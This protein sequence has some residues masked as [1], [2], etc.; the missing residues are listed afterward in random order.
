MKHYGDFLIEKLG[1]HHKYQ[2]LLT[3]NLFIIGFCA[4]F[5]SLYPILMFTQPMVKYY[6]HGKEIISQL[7]YT[8]CEQYPD[9]IILE[10]QSKK[11]WVTE[12][13]INCSKFDNSLL[14]EAIAIGGLL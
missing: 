9:Y 11:G 13:G 8:I 4:D 12:L 5:N 10:N 1:G 3:V 6:D 7:N 2:I 14:I